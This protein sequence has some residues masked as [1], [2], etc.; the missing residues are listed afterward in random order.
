[1]YSLI[2]SQKS[3]KKVKSRKSYFKRCPKNNKNVDI[4][5]NECCMDA[6]LQTLR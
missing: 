6:A 4:S 2:F 3:P 1:M 5:V